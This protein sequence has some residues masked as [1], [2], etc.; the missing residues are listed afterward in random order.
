ID[1]NVTNILSTVNT[2]NSTVN[3]IDTIVTNVN[4][5]V[6]D[7]RSNITYT[8]AVITNINTTVTRIDSTIILINTTVNNID[9][10][11]LDINST[12]ILINST[13]NDIKS[14]VTSFEISSLVAGSPRFP[15][16]EA[17][18]EA[19]FINQ[20]GNSVDPDTINLTI[21]D[22]NNNI[23]ANASKSDFTKNKVDKKDI[24]SFSKSISSNP[25]TGMYTAHMQASYKNITTSKSVQFRITVGGPFKISIDCPSSSA[26][27]SNLVCTVKITDEGEAAVESTCDTFVDTNN[28]E[29]AEASEP[30]QRRSQETVPQQN[31]TYDTSVNV[32]SSHA[33]GSFVVRI[34]CSFA[35]SAQQPSTAS[36]SVTFTAAA[37]PEEEAAPAA[38][39]A[40]GGGP[41]TRIPKP[42]VPDFEVIPTIIKEK[43]SGDQIVKKR[44]T[45]TNIG[46]AKL[47]LKI[48]FSSVKDFVRSPGNVNE[49][50]IG[51]VPDEEYNFDI[52]LFG[53]NLEKSGLY[54]NNIVVSDAGIEKKVN[55]ILEYEK[56]EP[57]FDVAV[58]VLEE[59]KKVFAGEDVFAEINLFNLRGVK[60]ADVDV[61]YSIKDSEGKT[62]VSDTTTISVETRT[63]F[64]RVLPLPFDT[65]PGNYIFSV[66]AE[67]SGLIGIGSDI[68]EVVE[69]PAIFKVTPCWPILLIFLLILAMYILYRKKE[70][71]IKEVYQQSSLIEFKYI[72]IIII[73]I[74]I[75]ALLISD[76]SLKEF[77]SKIISIIDLYSSCFKEIYVI[78]LLL[79]V[80]LIIIIDKMHQI[81]KPRQLEIKVKKKV[82]EKE[83]Q[84]REPREKA[85]SFEIFSEDKKKAINK[86]VFESLHKLGLVKTE[87]EKIELEKQRQK[88]QQQ[89]ELEREK[90]EEERLRK[91]LEMI[92]QEKLEQK[93]R[94]EEKERL[95]REKEKELKRE[96]LKEKERKEK[97]RDESKKTRRKEVF[98]LFGRLVLAKAERQK[99]ELEKKIQKEQ[100]QKELEREKKEEER[101]KE[102]DA[103]PKGEK[104]TEEKIKKQLKLL[105]ESFAS[106]LI[107]DSAYNEDKA[108]IEK[109][110][111]N[112][113]K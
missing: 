83:K 44:I 64:V 33:T 84:E 98:K 58:K 97:L 41:V 82:E 63:S 80:I 48:D 77:L 69:K 19:T 14:D 53:F 12:V 61:N 96:E 72:L 18:I 60:K 3:N 20:S 113:K 87:E 104:L 73:S 17:L 47:N 79:L 43:L 26:V 27:G 74:A 5:T 38:A 6:T 76:I 23:F 45:I 32:P 1:S 68:F 54:S 103:K 66:E 112:I 35:K 86:K 88:E 111:K 57:L 70:T 34:T 71:K 25:T 109:L 4:S 50:E 31:I 91:E 108:K 51:L 100:Q 39:P 29:T 85:K 78:G 102:V 107:S 10:V 22:P 99:K 42:K 106:G 90:K 55:V 65:E 8:N 30:Q 92:T 93:K 21:F 49:L 101:R 11:V 81:K 95:E 59:Y 110:L 75:S 15:D 52:T 36:D 28:N 9:S 37:A 24:W 94:E 46:T 67:Y 40:A 7:I 16:E 105:E 62:I 2:I 89:K 13:V 56:E